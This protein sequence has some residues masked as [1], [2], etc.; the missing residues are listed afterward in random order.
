M[1]LAMPFDADSRTVPVTGIAI[2]GC[3][4]AVDPADFHVYVCIDVKV[5]LHAP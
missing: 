4:D 5:V 1:V 3:D 2:G